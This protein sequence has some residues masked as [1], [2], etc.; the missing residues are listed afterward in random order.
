MGGN[1]VSDISVGRNEDGRLEIFGRGPDNRV[2]HKWQTTPDGYWSEW[3][4]FNSGGSFTGNISVGQNIT[5]TLEIF[6]RDTDNQVW[7]CWQ[8]TST[9]KDWTGWYNMGGNIVSDISVGH[10][11]DGRLEIFG[12]GPDNQ[13]H[14]KWQTTPDGYW[15]EWESLGSVED[16]PEYEPSTDNLLQNPG[17]ESGSANWTFGG[18]GAAII[19]TIDSHSHSGTNS[20]YNYI[21]SALWNAWN[22]ITVDNLAAGTY[23]AS[24]WV[25]SGGTFGE[26]AFQIYKNGVY[27][28]E[29]PVNVNGGYRQYIIN[30]ISVSEGDSIR[31]QGWMN[32]AE[33]DSW[34]NWDDF[35]L[36]RN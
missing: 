34:V 22:H 8:D 21:N 20:A 2:Y 10:N 32:N 4:S 16:S 11:E 18:T 5:G 35:S 1:I 15:S 29:I 27:Y 24:C 3:H 14:H 6:I 36:S 7:H 23:T 9:S 26:L 12:K 31:V 17:F 19:D 28:T 25:K 13:M 33:L 30:D